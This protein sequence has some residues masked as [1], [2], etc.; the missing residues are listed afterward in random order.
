M[1]LV[2]LFTRG[3]LNVTLENGWADFT[4]DLRKSSRL[5]QQFRLD[6]KRSMFDD[7]VRLDRELDYHTN[8]SLMV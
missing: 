6:A 1:C 3:R 4:E 7:C 5:K 8:L 2:V